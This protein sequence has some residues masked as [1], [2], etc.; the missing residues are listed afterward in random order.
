MLFSTELELSMIFSNFLSK[1]QKY[2]KENIICKKST[3]N[4]F[5]KAESV[6]SY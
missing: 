4:K 5:R 2:I 1:T 3:K 6:C